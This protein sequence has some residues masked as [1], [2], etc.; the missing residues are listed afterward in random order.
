MKKVG[1][2]GLG[3]MGL[4]MACNLLGHGYEILAYDKV[5]ENMDKFAAKGGKRAKNIAHLAKGA[6]IIISMLPNGKIVKNLMSANDGIFE[7][8]AKN[9]LIIDCSTIDVSTARELSSLAVKKNI[10]FIDAPVSGGVM[11]AKN[12]NLTFMCG[13]SEEDFLRAKPIL[14]LMGKNIIHAGGAGSGQAVK[15]CNNMLLGISMIGVSEAFNLADSLGLDR[16]KFF[17]I[18]A[19]S[20]GQCWSLTSYCP[21]PEMVDNSPANNDY[22]AGFSVAMM[23]K[24]LLLSQQAASE[25]GVKTPLGQHASE[26]YQAFAK[27]GYEHLD[28]SAIIKYLR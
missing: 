23:L 22:R 24:D 1:F 11:G 13:A 27:N 26:L 8:I 5:A 2:L 14:S 6:Q 10:S 15:L 3:N 7:N 16:K 17:D 20:S 12:A 19:I 4:P 25:N 21:V 18:A 9:S 28:F